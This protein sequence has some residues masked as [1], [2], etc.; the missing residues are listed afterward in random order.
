MN[1]TVDV[2]FLK[3]DE[4]GGKVGERVC[5]GAFSSIGMGDAL[6]IFFIPR[7]ADNRCCSHRRFDIIDSKIG[8]T[9]NQ[10]F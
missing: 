8:L 10:I 9:F 5:F 4:N 3:A 6:Q 7:I 2:I 1:K